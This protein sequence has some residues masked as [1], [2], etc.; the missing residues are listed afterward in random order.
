MTSEIRVTLDPHPT[1]FVD[2]ER[3][4][5]TT[6]IKY[7][8]G[9]GLIVDAITVRL[10]TPPEERRRNREAAEMEGGLRK[11]EESHAT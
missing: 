8:P 2:G 5:A 7:A 10:H 1:V 9:G 3:V 4:A 6:D 11:T